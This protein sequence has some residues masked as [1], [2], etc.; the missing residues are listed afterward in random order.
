MSGE[1]VMVELWKRGE[2]SAASLSAKIASILTNSTE[3]LSNRRCFERRALLYWREGYGD[4]V[5]ET[6]HS[7]IGITVLMGWRDG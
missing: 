6:V 7:A 4:I 1:K 3:I 2:K 5:A